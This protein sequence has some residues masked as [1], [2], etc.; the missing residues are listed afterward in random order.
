MPVVTSAA[1]MRTRMSI[2]DS[3][4]DA[5]LESIL[6][7][8]EATV[9]LFLG[10]SLVGGSVVKYLTGDGTQRLVL[11][12]RPVLSVTEVRE[13]ADGRFGDNG[14]AYGTATILT[15]GE[16]Y[17]VEIVSPDGVC[18]LHRLGGVWPYRQ[19]R[20]YRRLAN[21]KVPC[22]GS[23]MVTFLLDDC[24]GD[25]KQAIYL[26]AAAQYS[27]R[28]TGFGVQT[29]SSLDARSVSVTPFGNMTG[30]AL[31]PFISPAAYK[32]LSARRRSAIY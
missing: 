20:G 24:P 8:V 6:D 9:E 1:V 21:S 12:D 27:S 16:G 30:N 10:Y 15:A 29:S 22:E 26:E 2:P 7:G 19:W 4:S 3:V 28:K 13:D 31:N 5:V 18:V 25:V 17:A 23:V 14:D 32:M 11:P